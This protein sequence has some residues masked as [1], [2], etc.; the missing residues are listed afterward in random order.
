MV[1]IIT[2]FNREA[3]KMDGSCIKRNFIKICVG[4]NEKRTIDK[5]A[6][7]VANRI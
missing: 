7:Y 2:E 5:A 4:R 6:D 1:E 3:M